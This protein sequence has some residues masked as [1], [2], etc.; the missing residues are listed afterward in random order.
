MRPHRAGNQVAGH[1]TVKIFRHALAVGHP[2]QHHLVANQ[3][4]E[5]RAEFDGFIHLGQDGLAAIVVLERGQGFIQGVAMAAGIGHQ[6]LL[7]ARQLQHLQNIVLAGVAGGHTGG[8]DD[9]HF[10]A[11]QQAQQIFQGR[12]VM[13]QMGHDTEHAAIR[14]QLLVGTDPVGIQRDQANVLRPVSLGAQGGQFGRRGGFAHP[15][16][17]DQGKHAAHIVD[18]RRRGIGAQIALQ[19]LHQPAQRFC[20]GPGLGHALNQ[21]AGQGGRKTGANQLQDQVG[22]QWVLPR[23]P[24]PGQGVEAFFNQAFDG[25]QLLQHALAGGGAGRQVFAGRHLCGHGTQGVLAHH[26]GHGGGF[27]TVLAGFAGEGGQLVFRQLGRLDAF[28]AAAQHALTH[29]ILEGQG[30]HGQLLGIFGH[31]LARADVHRRGHARCHSSGHR[32]GRW[33]LRGNDGGRSFAQGAGF[34]GR[35]RLDG[36]AQPGTGFLATVH[37]LQVVF[38]RGHDFHALGGGAVGQNECA[39]AKNRPCFG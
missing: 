16:R 5:R 29:V 36:G 12:F 11:R 4:I 14:A 37:V 26:L 15:G 13:G 34:F 27:G 39:F 30:A 22:V 25:L 21:G 31:A 7:H 20:R 9:D 2:A 28:A 38:G 33:G 24:Q 8:V 17:T 10:L 19:H 3:G 35:P 18:G 6:Q 1:G 32:L 23:L